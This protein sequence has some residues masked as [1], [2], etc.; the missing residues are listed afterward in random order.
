M[1]FGDVNLSGVLGLLLG[2]PGIILGLTLAFLLAGFGS[3]IVIA[4]LVSQRRFNAF[5]TFIPYGPYL[6]LA[7]ALLMFKW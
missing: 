3:T 4:R 5:G 1:G 2:W 6:V 7:A